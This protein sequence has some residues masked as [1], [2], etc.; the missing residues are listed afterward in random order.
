MIHPIGI[1]AMSFANF[2]GPTDEANSHA[3]LDAAMQAGVDHIDTAN[4]YGM[5]TS[6]TVIGTYL[7][8]NPSAKDHFKI[9]TKASI[10]SK[11]DGTG[12][13]FDNS[14]E[15]LTS[16]LEKSLQRMGI[17]AVELFYVHRRNPDIPI[18]EVTATLAGLVKS[19]KT[20]AIGYSEIA[21]SSLRRAHAVHPVAAV[22]SE[23]SLSTRSPE[24]GLVQTCKELGAALVAFSPVGRSLLTDNPLSYEAVQDLPF[25]VNNPRFMEPNYSANITAIS[26]FQALASDM[27]ISAAGLAIAWVL[28]KGEHI[29]PIPGTRS[30]EHF[31][32]FLEGVDRPLTDE[33][34]KAVEVTLPIGWAHGDRYS[35]AQ[36]IGPERY[37]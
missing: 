34:I 35:Q 23:Y 22:Q 21:P 36:W 17:E 3:I 13:F 26:A 28:A 18:E 5:G 2:Y 8:A 24:M 20:K 14:A 30:V 31:K 11:P 27:N 7:K 1:G 32:E 12:R 4:V 9:A 19:G 37:C 33:E 25:L 6:E 16:E 29:I 10:S 15:H